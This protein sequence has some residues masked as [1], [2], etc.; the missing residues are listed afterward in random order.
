M[1]WELKP[2][3]K[4]HTAQK[5]RELQNLLQRKADKAAITCRLEGSKEQSYTSLG[6]ENRR[7]SSS[8][9]SLGGGQGQVRAEN[10]EVFRASG[11]KEKVA[12]TCKKKG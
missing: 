2:G 10:R 12:A 7:Q 1:R 8:P 6:K 9:N 11:R 5:G 3:V 4:F